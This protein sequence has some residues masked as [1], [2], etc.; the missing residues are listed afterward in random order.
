MKNS[1]KA[2]AVVA[3]LA[4]SSLAMAQDGASGLTRSQVRAQL[5]STR[6][7]AYNSVNSLDYPENMHGTSLHSRGSSA[8]GD[9]GTR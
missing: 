9:V 4:A 6:A 2:I 7:T 1:L 5:S 8:S 3:A